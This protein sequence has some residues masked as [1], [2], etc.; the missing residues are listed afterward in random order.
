[1]M[2]NADLVLVIG[3]FEFRICFVFLISCFVFPACPG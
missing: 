3:A 2:L 1:M